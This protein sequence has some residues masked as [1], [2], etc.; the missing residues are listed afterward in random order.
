MN[1]IVDLRHSAAFER[2][3]G[4]R[5][6]AQRALDAVAASPYVQKCAI[7]TTEELRPILTGGW[8]KNQQ[9]TVDPQIFRVL[10]AGEPYVVTAMRQ[11]GWPEA[12]V[13]DPLHPV[14]GFMLNEAILDGRLSTGIS[15]ISWIDAVR[16]G[17][18]TN[19]AVNLSDQKL[20]YI[21]AEMDA[22]AAWDELMEDLNE[23]EDI[24]IQH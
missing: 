17:G 24:P 11:F 23:Q 12:I 5:S 20:G 19:T 2:K 9:I 22:G 8:I 4:G 10:V 7:C 15:K 6:L 14:F 16:L 13:I 1:C 21:F 3:F 18:P